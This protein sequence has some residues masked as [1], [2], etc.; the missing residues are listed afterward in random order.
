VQ[1]TEILKIAK[2]THVEPHAERHLQCRFKFTHK[3][4]TLAGASHRDIDRKI[5][6]N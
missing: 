6:S 3:L 1:R 2:R 4:A 5:S